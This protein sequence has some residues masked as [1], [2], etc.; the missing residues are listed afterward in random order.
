[1]P[2]DPVPH[3]A[4]LKLAYLNTD[5]CRHR[6]YLQGWGSRSVQQAW[7]ASNKGFQL[8]PRPLPDTYFYRK[9][10]TKKGQLLAE[11]GELRG[12]GVPFIFWREDQSS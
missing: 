3:S 8:D 9:T 2:F 7:L 12:D 1:M 10:G 6:Y 5:V 11:M 4:A